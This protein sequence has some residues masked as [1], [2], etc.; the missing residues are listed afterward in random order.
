MLLNRFA[1]KFSEVKRF[2]FPVSKWDGHLLPRDVQFPV[3]TYAT[4]QEI[5]SNWEK[6]YTIR[7]ME[8][9][10][11]TLYSQRLIRGFCHLYDGQEA[12]ATGMENALNHK[13]LVI[14][15]YRDHANAYLRGISIY[16]IL[17]E[18]L[19]KKDGSS[20]AK[21]GSMHFYSKKNNFYGGN[22]IVGAQIPVGV[23]LGFSLKHHKNN[24]NVAVAIFGDGAA[25]QGQLYE[26]ANMAGLWKLPVIFVCEMNFFAMGTSVER[27]SFGGTDFHK[28]VYGMPGLKVY[29]QCPFEVQAAFDFAKKWAINNGPIYLNIE[30]YRYK[31]HSMSDPGTTYRVK[32][33][34]DLW[35]TERD[36]VKNLKN[37]ILDNKIQ[38]EQE[39]KEREKTI[40]A[41]IE[42][43]VERAMESPEAPLEYLLQD[44]YDPKVK[45]Y[46]RA[47]NYEDSVFVKEKMIN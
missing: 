30:T 9:E 2:A 47:P 25:N 26:A 31:G 41:F 19:G 10:T 42:H 39:M 43:E 36:P 46:L 15:A 6:M 27:S 3:E 7:R 11:D 21:G 33:M 35:K 37:Y 29:G 20:R 17:T 38:T 5:L 13:D 12:L 23:G 8:I 16:E 4:E 24:E 32:E 1:R 28:K 44:V 45:N 40:K 22:G 34:H 18:M 14:T